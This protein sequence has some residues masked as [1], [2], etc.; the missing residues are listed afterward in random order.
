MARVGLVL[1]AGL[2]GEKK[3]LLHDRGERLGAL[4]SKS[5]G[6]LA[7]ATWGMSPAQISAVAGLGVQRFFWRSSN[8]V[9]GKKYPAAMLECARAYRL[10]R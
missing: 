4:F 7:R 10:W 1:V 3:V 5:I 2:K 8:A 9:V 6:C